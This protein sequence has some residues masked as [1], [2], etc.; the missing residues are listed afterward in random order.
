MELS[1]HTSHV[2]PHVDDDFSTQDEGGE[3]PKVEQRF[4]IAIG[5]ERRQTRPPQKYGYSDLVAYVLTT[6]EDMGIHEPDTYS[7]VVTCRESEKWVGVMAE[8]LESLHKNKTWE[9]VKLPKGK[10]AIGL[11]WVYTKEGIHD[12]ENARFKA[13]LMAKGFS[14]KRALIMMRYS[15]LW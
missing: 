9:L 15:H 6:V 11:K 13:R 10:K 12:V 8:E 5:R 4:S 1:V 7:N 3:S 2:P 14:Q